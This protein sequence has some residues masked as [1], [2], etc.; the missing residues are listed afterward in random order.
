MSEHLCVCLSGHKLQE[1]DLRFVTN[2][3]VLKHNEHLFLGTLTLQLQTDIDPTTDASKH[4]LYRMKTA[5]AE[6]SKVST[7][8]AAY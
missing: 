7:T 2:K 4:E 3:S 6:Q 5:V 1:R 8:W